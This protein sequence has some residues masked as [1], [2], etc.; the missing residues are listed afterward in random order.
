MVLT[1][2][3]KSLIGDA[4]PWLVTAC[5]FVRWLIMELCPPIDAAERLWLAWLGRQILTTGSLPHMLGNET[6]N[7]QGSPWLPQEWCLATIIAWCELHNATLLFHIVFAAIA[8]IP[9]IIVIAQFQKQRISVTRTLVA[10][11]FLWY[12]LEPIFQIRANTLALSCTALFLW[13][14]R[15]GNTWLW[16]MPLLVALTCN[17][18]ASGLF[19]SVLPLVLLPAKLL[20]EQSFTAEFRRYSL[21]ALAAFTASFCTPFG[22]MLWK[23]T[24]TLSNP[25]GHKYSNEWDSLW[26]HPPFFDQIIALFCIGIGLYVINLR[27]K[28]L[29]FRYMDIALIGMTFCM[30]VYAERFMPLFALVITPLAFGVVDPAKPEDIDEAQLRNAAPWLPI[31]ITTLAAMLLL[32]KAFQTLA[33]AGPMNETLGVRIPSAWHMPNQIGSP[34]QERVFCNDF[35]DCDVFLDAG[36]R[37]YNDGRFDPYSAAIWQQTYDINFQKGNWLGALQRLQ[38]NVIITRNGSRLDQALK[39]QPEWQQHFHDGEESAYILLSHS[40]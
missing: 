7:A 21:A 17:V 23:Y 16:L 2:Q 32:L 40:K 28:K 4:L 37:V 22:Y 33:H 18:H 38:V 36:A 35:L 6:L 1:G 11:L 15:K 29:A 31:A 24:L 30:T 12:M 20:D 10:T 9:C 3:R 5:I 39:H 8:C 19:L 14:L 13:A 27:T 25:A 26:T 34:A